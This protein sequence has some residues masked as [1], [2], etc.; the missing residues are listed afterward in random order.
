V[1]ISHQF[2]LEALQAI[3]CLL[4]F[5]FP[6]NLSGKSFLF[7]LF[8]FQSSMNSPGIVADFSCGLGRQT[9]T[10]RQISTYGN[11]CVGLFVFVHTSIHLYMHMYVRQEQGAAK[12]RIP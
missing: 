3:A 10:R 8:L 6:S 5:I 4:F 1:P 11:R 2:H 12:S 7:R 9:K